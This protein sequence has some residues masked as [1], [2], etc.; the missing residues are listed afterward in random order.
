MFLFRDTAKES[1]SY[2]KMSVTDVV[3]IREVEKVL[4]MKSNDFGINNT[5]GLNIVPA[6]FDSSYSLCDWISVP[7]R[8]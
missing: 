2:R 5:F 8:R 6:V 3:S 4:S 7:W 1:L